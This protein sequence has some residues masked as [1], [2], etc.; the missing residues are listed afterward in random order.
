MIRLPYCAVCW[1]D[2]AMRYFCVSVSSSM[3][4]HCTDNGQQDWN[5]WFKP[6]FDFINRQPVIK[7]LCYINWDWAQKSKDYNL[8]WGDWGDCRIEANNT[9][10]N[11]Y[12]QE[13]NKALY[14][15]GQDEKAL[16]KALGVDDTIPPGKATNLA[17]AFNRNSVELT[18]QDAEDNTK[19][20][21]YEIYRNGNLLG[22][23]HKN[24]YRDKDIKAGSSLSYSVRAVDMGANQGTLADPVNVKIPVSIAKVTGGNFESDNHEWTVR[25]WFGERLIFSRETKHALAGKVSAKLFVEKA[26]GT[27]WHVQFGHFFKSYKGMKY[28]LSFT[29][30]ADAHAEIEVLLQQTHEPYA[31]IISVTVTADTN[32][33]EFTFVNTLPAQDDSLFLSFM[34]GKATVQ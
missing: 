31:A 6:Y 22:T 10:A 19:V 24:T 27:D 28:T 18:W 23:T 13:M 29:I 32:P 34:C 8:P 15:H 16:R 21:R 5:A 26:S 2:W 17:T 7:A 14:F 33:K 25:E 12:K 3:A 9:I 30:Q 20:L 4:C 11:L 1:T